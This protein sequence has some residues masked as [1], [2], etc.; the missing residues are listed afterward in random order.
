VTSVFITD[1][2]RVLA[3]RLATIGNPWRSLGAV[4][5][6]A[7]LF[8]LAISD[9]GRDLDSLTIAQALIFVLFALSVWA[10]VA[11]S[12]AV[13]RPLLVMLAV[14]MLASI[15]SVRLE[16]SV[17]EL[18][19][20]LMYLGITTIAAL[21]TADGTVAR[22]FLDAVIAIGGWL[23]LIALFAF[24]G[25]GDPS[26][27]WY[28]TFYWPNPF[29]AFL[30]LLLPPTF[31]RYLHAPR[32][33]EALAHGLMTVLFV[34]A[35]V[36][37]Y[38]RGAWIAL[39][40][41]APVAGIVLRPMRWGGVAGRMACLI[42]L[43]GALV[44][45]LGRGPT[46][47]DPGQ[48]VVTR[49]ASVANLSDYAIR[50]RLSFWRAGL[51]IFEGH[52]LLGTG[53]GTFA[54]MHPAYQ[55]DVRY[56]ARD[57]HN[58]YI[59]TLA[60]LGVVGLAA[61]V[62]LLGSVGNM[63]RRALRTAQGREEYPLIAGVGVGLLAFFLH[64]AFDMDWMFPANPAMAFALI[65]LLAG[66]DLSRS[67][68]GASAARQPGRWAAGP[69][70]STPRTA[71]VRVL[72]LGVLLLAL[73]ATS[74]LWAA[75]RAFGLG[76]D[77]ARRGEWSLAADHYAAA[78]RWNPLSSRYLE[79]YASAVVRTPMPGPARAAE[80]LRRAMIVDRMNAAFPEQLAGLL[81]ADA[82]SPSHYAEVEALIRRAITLDPLNRPEAYG[83]LAK[84]YLQQGRRDD[85]AYVYRQ[86]ISLY[87]GKGLGQGSMIYLLLWP[88]VTQLVLDASA[89]AATQGDLPQA[90][91]VL[92]QLLAEDP[93]APAV[94][95][96]LSEIYVQMGQL[97]AA[98][99]VLEGAAA[100]EPEN[101]QIRAALQA[102]SRQSY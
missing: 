20:W 49:A 5:L 31:M 9:G 72:A 28:S 76:R 22:R 19:L 96:R 75:Q 36:F 62:T 6:V 66:Y 97:R 10:G 61:L 80:L 57:A 42:A 93:G 88:Q 51:E 58:L 69:L 89:A 2:H 50:G 63:W 91:Q 18:L 13:T 87:M 16:A 77:A 3:W 8:K 85:A 32:I 45:A 52:P 92:A 73:A 29:A 30:L 40:A 55:R 46:P 90:A 7:I 74:V 48:R 14:V 71:W 99:T 83:I 11:S 38:S 54:S 68:E 101:E 25:A 53:A 47:Q 4:A 15:G 37:T 23:C 33:R 94:A 27:R 26:M 41:V 81:L 86:A 102:L 17:R 98:R 1:I 95:L 84:V 70:A 82:S 56:Y 24:W 34:V 60:E 64:S 43:A 67:S 35:L 59:Q 21:A 44:F 78:V 65:G 100:R 39:G 79:A 12:T